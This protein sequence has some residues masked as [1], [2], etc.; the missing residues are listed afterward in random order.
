MNPPR[1]ITLL[2]VAIDE[3]KASIGFAYSARIDLARARPLER[4][5]APIEPAHQ[6]PA[7]DPT[8]PS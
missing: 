8:T 3:L 6:A 5:I 2:R 7:I 1:P 4:T